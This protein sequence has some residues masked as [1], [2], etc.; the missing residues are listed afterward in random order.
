[1][2]EYIIIIS[3]TAVC[4]QASMFIFEDAQN[5]NSKKEYIEKVKKEYRRK[6][7]ISGHKIIC[8]ATPKKPKKYE[9]RYDNGKI[10]IEGMLWG[11]RRHGKWTF[12]KENGQKEFQVTF[13]KG[14][15]L[16]G[17][18]CCWDVDGNEIQCS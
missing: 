2:K 3:I 5:E 9:K 11:S 7:K 6:H 12:F 4:L 18:T 14:Q 16:F 10:M 13:D 17:S 15:I 8:Y 1:M